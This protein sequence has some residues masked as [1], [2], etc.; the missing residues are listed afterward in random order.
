MEAVITNRVHI[1]NVIRN[2]IVFDFKNSR[3]GAVSTDTLL[4]T[5]ARLFELLDER[6]IDYL[7]VGGV[8][9]LQYT[10]R[11]LSAKVRSG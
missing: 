4:Q 3:G 1:G 2:A 8:A 7:L 6:Q 9:L 5:V 10:D 11:S